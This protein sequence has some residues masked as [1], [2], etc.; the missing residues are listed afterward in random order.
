MKRSL[1][2]RK[3]KIKHISL[4]ALRK[5]AWDLQSQYIRRLA[6]GV[7]FT[8]GDHRKWKEVFA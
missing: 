4:K 8:C 5:K 6:R 2:K 1:L 3:P 7:C